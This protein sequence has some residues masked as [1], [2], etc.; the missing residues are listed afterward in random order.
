VVAIAVS[1]AKRSSSFLQKRTKKLFP[2]ASRAK[3]PPRS[4][5]NGFLLL[6]CKQEAL[7]YAFVS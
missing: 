1:E 3:R 5:F 6:F 2:G 7:A 4:A